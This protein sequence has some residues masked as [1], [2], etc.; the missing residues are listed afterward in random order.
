MNLHQLNLNDIRGFGRKKPALAFCFLMGALGIGGIPLWSGYISKTLIHESIVEYIE[1]S[2]RAAV[3]RA[4]EWVFLVTGGMTVA[5]MLKLFIA[6]F[7]EKHPDRQ[8]EFDGMTAPQSYMRTASAAAL[9]VPAVL[10]PLFGLTPHLTMDRLADLGQGFFTAGGH[11]HRV[12]YFSFTN[13]KGGIISIGIGVFLYA[14]VIR[15]FLMEREKEEG[16]ER[17]RRY[18]DRWPSWLDL[19]NLIYRP[20]LQTALPAVFGAVCG[21]VDRYLVSV[22]VN[23]FLAVSSVAC[24]A[25]DQGVDGV[26][27]LARATTHRQQPEPKSRHDKNGLA[28]LL[29]EMADAA[30][31]GKNHLFGKKRGSGE[32]QGDKGKSAVPAMI[33]REEQWKQTWKLIEESFSFGLMLFCIGL[34]LTLGYLLAAVFG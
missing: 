25:M 17:R 33:R 30:A 7:V 18:V 3:W 23:V 32:P 2:G 27:R 15:G 24:R 5:Y 31:L 19:E 10:L 8:E 11:G 34:C 4:A 1:F 29:G 22:S 28:H 26:I 12:A 13:L 6:L 21:F 9:T 16:G 14:V 20:V